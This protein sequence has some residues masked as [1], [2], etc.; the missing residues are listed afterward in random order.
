MTAIRRHPMF[1]ALRELRGNPRACVLTEPMF[2]VPFNMYHPFMSV[3]MLA[4][5][6]TDQGIGLIASL[7]L[8]SQIVSTIA[9]GAIVDK[10]GRR[11]TLLIADIVSFAV[12]CLI[13]AASQ[14]MTYFVVA[15]LINGTWRISHTAWTCLMIEDA[16][17]RHLV[18]IWSWI[19]IF[20]VSTSFFTPLGGWFVARYGLVPAMRGLLVFS[21]VM[22]TAKAVILFLFS[23]ETDRGVQRRVETRNQSLVSL[24]GEYRHVIGELATS[25]P[26]RVA[27]SLMIITNIFGTINGSFWGV[28]FTAKMGLPQAS[29]SL[30][31]ALG[32]IVTAACM[33]L[34]GPRFRNL[35]HFRMPLWL[36]FGLYFVSQGLLVLM[37]ERAVLLLVVSVILA[38][39]AAALVN[40][41]IESLLAVALESHER[42]RISAMVY[43]VLLLFTT[44]FGWIAG[45]LSAIDRVLPFAFNMLL[46]VAGA[47]LVWRIGRPRSALADLEQ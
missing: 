43:A 33:F 14:N 22:L 26:I 45:Q 6:V 27:L 36:G 46:F 12:P 4:L 19:T 23:H 21:F 7:S 35:L 5:G 24:L 1:Q 11:L 42:A 38:A 13:W 29:I 25:R 47:L 18:H 31:A 8:L 17:A 16:E 37:P 30:F 15:A 39:V 9:S 40:P 20:G 2:G 32:S 34:I 10:Y 28:L 41:M 44:P 3:Y